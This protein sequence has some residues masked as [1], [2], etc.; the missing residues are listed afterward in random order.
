MNSNLAQTW[1]KNPFV[2]KHVA[3]IFIFG[4]SAGVP[5]LLI[6]SSLG[7]WL[8]E[9]GVNRATVTL[10]SWAALAY[11]FKFIWAP[12]VDKIPIPWLTK[13]LGRRRAWLLISQ[14]CVILAIFWLSSNNPALGSNLQLMALATVLLGFS[15]ATQDIVIDAYRIESAPPEMQAIMSSS[16]IA[17]YRIG[18]LLAG[19]GALY[20]ASFLGSTSGNYNF[21]AW[22]N[23]Y[24]VM[25]LVMLLGVITTLLIKEPKV[26]RIDNFSYSALDY[27]RLFLLFCLAISGLIVSYRLSLNPA[28]ELK[29]YLADL[30][31][32][33]QISG[34]IVESFRL[35]FG[36]LV[37]IIIAFFGTKLGLAKQE[38]VVSSYLKPIKEFFSR[39][40]IALALLVLLLIGMYRISDIVLGVIANIF[41]QDIGFSK[42]EIATI[43]KT[44]GLFMTIG[45]GFAGGVIVI[46]YGVMRTLFLGA[47]LTV[48]TNLF[49][50]ILANVGANITLLYLVISADNLTAG[51]ATTAFIAFLSQLTNVKFTASQYAIFSS[52]MTLIPKLIGGYSGAI[53][54]N[55]GYS[56]FF[57][58]ASFLGLPII[59]LVIIV[60]NKLRI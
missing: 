37:A 23:T 28:S 53:V 33:K 54:N 57:L 40:S 15:S 9:A 6:F 35:S 30:F 27:L 20:L 38:M 58:F 56:N 46:K 60:R 32:N 3:I 47:V 2:F 42:V 19:A 22:S 5:L 4:I 31:H 10:F 16:Y 45:G 14:L 48:I 51:I 13:T 21:Q 59:F 50:I 24:Q 29:I 52:L 8:R 17:G 43:V 7:L 12:L 36:L 18:M 49:F 55:I 41:Y 44:F 26:N 11:S 1:Y 34:F 25:A 39:Y